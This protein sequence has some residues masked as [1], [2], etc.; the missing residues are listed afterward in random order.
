MRLLEF[1]DLEYGTLPH[2]SYFLDPSML[3]HMLSALQCSATSYH[4]DNAQPH[5]AGVIMLSHMLSGWDSWKFTDLG[6]GTLPHQS[7]SL[8]SSSTDYHLFLNVWIFSMPKIFH[9]KGGGG[10]QTTLKDFVASKSLEFH[11]TC[12]NNFGNR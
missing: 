10:V 4:D 2:P 9:S 12:I 5:V 11:R 8:D 1:T 6:Y 7:Y 3:S